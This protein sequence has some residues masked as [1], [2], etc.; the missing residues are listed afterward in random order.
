M[1]NKYNNNNNNV[2]TPPGLVFIPATTISLIFYSTFRYFL[3]E[4]LKKIIINAVK[5]TCNV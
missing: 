4:G 1:G 3:T 5:I 2:G